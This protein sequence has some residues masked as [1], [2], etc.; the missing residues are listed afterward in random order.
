[1]ITR[2]KSGA[3]ALGA[4]CFL[5]TCSVRDNAPLWPALLTGLVGGVLLLIGR[6]LERR[7]SH[8]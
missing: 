3:L 7:P 4:F 5:L 8:V 2:A 1:M 6:P